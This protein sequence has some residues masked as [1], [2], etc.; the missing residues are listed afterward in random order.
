MS[1]FQ[2]NFCPLSA[3]YGISKR[4]QVERWPSTFLHSTY[5]KYKIHFNQ[6]ERLTDERHLEDKQNTVG[7]SDAIDWSFFLD[8]GDRW[9]DDIRTTILI[10]IYSPSKPVYKSVKG[11]RF[12]KCNCVSVTVTG[13]NKLVMKLDWL[14][15]V[16]VDNS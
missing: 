9:S 5:K 11:L 13:C 7:W 15:Y 3:V 14:I 12:L 10:P 8:F 6:T 16:Q 2:Y 1:K 4:W